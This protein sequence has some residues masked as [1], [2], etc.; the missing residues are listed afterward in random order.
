[1]GSDADGFI[2]TAYFTNR[3]ASGREVVWTRSESWRNRM[4]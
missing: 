4:R 2:L 1:M 3:P